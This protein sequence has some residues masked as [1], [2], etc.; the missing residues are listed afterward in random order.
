MLLKN[1]ADQDPG[2]LEMFSKLS[3][4]IASIRKELLKYEPQVVENAALNGKLNFLIEENS[5]ANRRRAIA[6]SEDGEDAESVKKV[7]E[8]IEIY[9]KSMRQT[10]SKIAKILGSK[11]DEGSACDST[12]QCGSKQACINHMCESVSSGTKCA[13]HSECGN[14]AMCI[15]NKCSLILAGTPCEN[16]LYDCGNNMACISG[17]CSPLFPR[18][19]EGGG[20]NDCVTAGDCAKS[21]DC[22]TGSC[23]Y[24]GGG[25]PCFYTSQCGNG[26]ICQ[27]ITFDK[28]NEFMYIT[29]S[30]N[31]TDVVV[32]KKGKVEGGTCSEV[33]VKSYCTSHGECGRNSVCNLEEYQCMPAYGLIRGANIKIGIFLFFKYY[34]YRHPPHIHS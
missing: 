10:K 9:S 12:V 8:E 27:P 1:G 24:V 5:D 19:L 32:N 18:G 33:K 11:I 13:A 26:D 34:Y 17:S 2:L 15:T 21:Q 23:L 6:V 20:E 22:I 16:T 30:I 3:R 7:D 29:E 31:S 25:I 4:E 28:E 14:G